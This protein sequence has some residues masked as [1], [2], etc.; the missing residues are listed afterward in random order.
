VVGGDE[1]GQGRTWGR[2]IVGGGE[3][4]EEEGQLSRA[5]DRRRNQPCLTC[6]PPLGESYAAAAGGDL[7][8]SGVGHGII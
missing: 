8:R 3:R 5:E 4:G 2:Q 6:V 1:S 7:A